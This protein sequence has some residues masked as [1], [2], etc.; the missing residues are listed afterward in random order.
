[1]V[2][3]FAA[4]GPGGPAA[5]AE[6]W[7]RPRLHAVAWP[8]LDAIDAARLKLAKARDEH[9]E[10]V[11]AK[12][13]ERKARLSDRKMP[14]PPVPLSQWEKHSRLPGDPRPP[15]P[16][17]IYRLSARRAGEAPRPGTFKHTRGHSIERDVLPR[18]RAQLAALGVPARGRLSLLALL[19]AL[20]EPS[21]RHRPK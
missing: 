3:R 1:M 10:R 13:R 7:K 18:L 16:V 14:P 19:A 17:R 9:H 20:A 8:I 12:D 2:L 4:L 11:K 6:L 5:L 21:R 15:L